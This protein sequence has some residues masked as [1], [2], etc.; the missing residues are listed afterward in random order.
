MAKS[1]FALEVTNEFKHVLELA[2][3]G[4]SLFVT[5][6]AGTGKSTLLREIQTALTDRTIVVAAPTGV[7]ALNVDGL[8]IHR[9]FAFRKDLN[10]ELDNYSPPNTI[11][12]LE[13]L[14][15]DEVSMVRADILDWISIALMKAKKNRLPFGGIQVIFFGDLY[16]LPP[17]I[18]DREEDTFFSGYAS[19]YFFA[20]KSFKDSKITT[21]E[22]SKVFRQRQSNFVSLLNSLRDGT[23]GAD[24][25]N[26]LNEICL[27]DEVAKSHESAITLCNTN[28]DAER[29]NNSQLE[30]L[31]KE[32]VEIYGSTSGQVRKEDKK[33]EDLLR[34]SVGARVMM[35]VNEEPYVNGSLATVIDIFKESGD[36]RVLVKLDDF[37]EL[38]TVYPHT[39]EIFEPVRV[40]KKVEKRVIGTFRQI[41]M[42]LAWAITVHKSQGL[43]FQQ[44]IY[45]KGRGTFSEGQLYV[46]LSRCTTL[47]GLILRKR[48]T[49]KD[50]KVDRAISDFFESLNLE[51][52]D[53]KDMSYLL[54]SF[55][56][57]GGMRFDKCVE[58]ACKIPDDSQI[59]FNTLINPE[60]DLTRAV[61]TGIDATQLSLAPRFNQVESILRLLFHN[62][63]I[64]SQN[65]SR[66][67]IALPLSN[68]V[69][70][71]GL[72][73]SLV[74][75]GEEDLGKGRASDV[76]RL[77]IKT[78]AKQKSQLGTFKPSRNLNLKVEGGSYLLAESEVNH[79]HLLE[80][81]GISQLDE[82]SRARLLAATLFQ[83]KK[84]KKNLVGNL[85]KKFNIS[86]E[87][88]ATAAKAVLENLIANAEA[89][90][91]TSL[92]EKEKIENYASLFKMELDLEIGQDKEVLIVPGMKVCLTGSPPAEEEFAHLTKSEL[93][94]VLT[95]HRLE[96]VPSITKKCQ[97][98]VAFNKESLSG[99]A[100]RARELGI[101]VISSQEFLEIVDER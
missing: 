48:L 59:T 82:T 63:V 22:L 34:L 86:R 20:A 40:G 30:S 71:W 76:L 11:R 44:V 70:E 15:I 67:R 26:T 100:K 29:I 32:I 101:P 98:V 52:Q 72:G 49:L 94:K 78:L 2:K 33:T 99:K 83:D 8:T 56:S 42:R 7:A 9:L 58:I 17:V 91:T 19:T 45:D 96:E 31:N 89:N 1:K 84:P 6:K 77:N 93:R 80:I 12:D 95:S 57:T 60:R 14:L 23:A 18:D 85:C 92:V 62:K 81:L 13:V 53:V 66:L 10:S 36:Y 46:A 35:L 54:V 50:I 41:P 39:W 79:E 27:K 16:Q 51:T 69:F 68:E 21:I 47:E 43:T 37:E 25:L 61:N 87:S 75:R 73:L 5:G 38:V 3:A 97:L 88:A 64:V 90:G 74:E 65:F 28:L 55:V 4:Q 24:E